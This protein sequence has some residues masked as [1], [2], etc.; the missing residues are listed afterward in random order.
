MRDIALTGEG[1]P[2]VEK[3]TDALPSQSQSQPPSS[4]NRPTDGNDGTPFRPSGQ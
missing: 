4:S 3:L 1:N 2:K